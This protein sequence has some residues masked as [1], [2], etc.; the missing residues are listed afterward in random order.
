MKKENSMINKKE[1][2]KQIKSTLIRCMHYPETS[3]TAFNNE[4]FNDSDDNNNNENDDEGYVLFNPFIQ[5]TTVQGQIASLGEYISWILG[6]EAVLE[7]MNLE[8]NKMHNL[9]P[10]NAD[11]DNKGVNFN[12]TNSYCHS[13]SNVLRVNIN[14]QYNMSEESKH[15]RIKPKQKLETQKPEKLVH[16]SLSPSMSLV[17]SHKTNSQRDTISGYAN[18]IKVNSK[19]KKVKRKN[20][21]THQIL[22]DN[23]DFPISNYWYYDMKL[24]T[25]HK[26]KRS[27][28][29]LLGTVKYAPMKKTSSVQRNK[30]YHTCTSTV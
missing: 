17:F 24:K 21:T 10:S 6:N 26:S 14:D 13:K 7:N 27:N 8:Y 19:R 9:M 25:M 30:L 5:T 2:L 20:Y 15:K 3:I 1:V 28:E 4:C 18:D 23:I 22:H 29:N 12:V 11:D 16:S